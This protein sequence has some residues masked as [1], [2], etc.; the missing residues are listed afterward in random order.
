MSA[1]MLCV[2]ARQS[3]TRGS[4]PGCKLT[5][6][7]PI[8]HL[9][10]PRCSEDSARVQQLHHPNGTRSAGRATPTITAPS[11]PRHFTQLPS[12]CLIQSLEGERKDPRMSKHT[13]TAWELSRHSLLQREKPLQGK[14]GDSHPTWTPPASL[15]LCSLLCTDTAFKRGW[16]HHPL[17]KSL[18]TPHA[19][20]QFSVSHSFIAWKTFGSMQSLL[21]SA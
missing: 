3:Q 20:N 11:R 19:K 16:E 21:G 18:N 5:C 4:V 10:D 17:L 13:S 1:A 14:D 6:S 15:T 2:E 9:A 7:L 12:C 8:P